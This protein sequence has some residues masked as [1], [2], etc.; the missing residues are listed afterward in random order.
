[1]P[2]RRTDVQM[3]PDE[4]RAYLKENTKLVIV[5]NGPRGFP[6]PMPMNYAVDE[7]GRILMTTFK[8]SQKVLNLRR[9]PRATLLVETGFAYNDLK[10]VVAYANAEIIEEPDLV[11]AALQMMSKITSGPLQTSEIADQVRASVTKRVILRFK[12]SDYLS[13]DHSKLQGR[14]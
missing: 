4:I 3:S 11:F 12:P 10:S 14:Y 13:W 9:D 5:T 6:H 8:K 1:M 2:S 7:D